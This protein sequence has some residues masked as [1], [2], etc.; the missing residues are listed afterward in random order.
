MKVNVDKI[1]KNVLGGPTIGPAIGRE[2]GKWILYVRYT[3]G[4]E[5]L[6]RHEDWSKFVWLCGET[7]RG[8][9]R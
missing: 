5:I 9:R 2:D 7:L 4:V 8:D 3:A 6:C 1:L